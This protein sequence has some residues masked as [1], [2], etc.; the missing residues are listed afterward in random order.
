MT[1]RTAKLPGLDSL[2]STLKDWKFRTETP[3]VST[4]TIHGQSHKVEKV[5]QTKFLAYSPWFEMEIQV[6]VRRLDGRTVCVDTR[7][8]FLLF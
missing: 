3:Q 2:G 8:V 6:F 4:E 5:S 7:Q 1:R